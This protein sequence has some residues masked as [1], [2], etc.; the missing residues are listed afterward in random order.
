VRTRL[1]LFLSL[2]PLLAASKGA[3]A[4][5]YLLPEDSGKAEVMGACETCHGVEAV[6]IHKRSPHQWDTIL[7]QMIGL[8]ATVTDDQ[9]QTIITYLNAHFGQAMD[10][11]PAPPPLRGHGPG[12]ALALE[13][14]ETAQKTCE[15]QGHHVSTLVVDSLGNTIVLLTGDGSAP[16]ISAI[17]ARKTAVV[18][19]FEQPS[20]VV[21]KRLESDPALV[22]QIKND[23]DIGEVRQGGLPIAAHGELLGAIAVAGAFGPADTDEKCAKVGLERIA[24]RLR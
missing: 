14:A 12:L 18:L 5:N 21:M 20:G 17:A 8:G 4:Q 9:K 10:Y 16:I 11:V 3:G 19:K 2:L 7:Q 15:S 24:S 22:A 6:I 23:P 1:A 13:A